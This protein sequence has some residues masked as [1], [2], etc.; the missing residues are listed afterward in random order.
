MSKLEE[1]YR[2]MIVLIKPETIR[3]NAL[4]ICFT[5]TTLYYVDSVIRKLSDNSI[6]PHRN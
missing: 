4:T 6:H 3:I 2:K 5:D 1:V